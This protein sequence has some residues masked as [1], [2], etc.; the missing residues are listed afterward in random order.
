MVLL[1][2]PPPEENRAPVLAV[3][4]EVGGYRINGLLGRGGMGMVYEATQLSLGRTVALKV[5]AHDLSDDDAF[6]ERFRREGRIQAGIDHD[7]IVTVYEAGEIDDGLFIAMR[8]IRGPNLKE[9]IRAGALDPARALRVLGPVA[10]ALDTAHEAGLVHRDVKP[11]NIL[12][13]RRDHGY[14]ADFGLTRAST[15]AGFTQTGRFVGTPDYI[16][17]EQLQGDVPDAR[18][19]L[20]A[21][22]A[23]AYECLTGSV[24]FPRPTEAAVLFAHMSA[25]PPRVTD[26]RPDLPAAVDTVVARAMAK[27]PAVRHGSATELTEDLRTALGVASGTAP[28]PLG[29]DGAPP[30]GDATEIRSRAGIPTFADQRRPWTPVEPSIREPEPEPQRELP[31][32][33]EPATEAGPEPEPE[34]E[35]AFETFEDEPTLVDEPEPVPAAAPEIE[36]PADPEQAR[37]PAR[38][39]VAAARATPHEPVE[40]RGVPSAAGAAGGV[41]RVAHAVAGGLAIG[42]GSSGG[43]PPA[44]TAATISSGPASV[45]APAGWHAADTAPAVSGLALAAPH[46]AS[47]GAS[48]LTVGTTHATGPTLLPATFTA[49]LPAAPTGGDRVNLGGV[50]ALRFAGLRA[51]GATTPLTVFAAPTERGVVT[52]VCS[53]SAAALADCERA[54]GTLHLTGA[55]A[56]AL[57]PSADYAAALGSALAALDRL[58]GPAADRLRQAGTAKGQASAADD[59]RAAYAR[60]A[61]AVRGLPAGPV[62]EPAQRRLA[63]ALRQASDAYKSLAAAAH[64]NHRAAYAAA[65]ARVADAQ[66]SIAAA[67]ADFRRDGYRAV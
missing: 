33:P 25:A 58:R 63:G 39:P 43:D 26:R 6:R 9:L 23:V 57:G 67:Q 18:S 38:A 45:R 54:A 4:T 21:L 7:H 12:V 37:E 52:I 51:R 60:A 28:A 40:R 48:R 62:E 24:P 19:D 56:T 22:G 30:A 3:G 13:D 55:K 14:L 49:R 42:G 8:L 27:D 10:D 32:A 50:P 17:P 65:R 36:S 29:H 66:K 5:L 64:G 2:R 47:S 35:P 59:L 1:R 34:P 15:D 41:A 20:Y 46:S 53:A 11:H 31:R 61:T 44:A 16:A